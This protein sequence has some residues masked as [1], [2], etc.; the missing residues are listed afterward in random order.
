MFRCGSLAMA[1]MSDCIGSD[2]AFS[3]RFRAV[4]AASLLRPPGIAPLRLHDARTRTARF[5]CSTVPCH[6]RAGHMPVVR[7]SKSSTASTRFDKNASESFF[8]KTQ[9]FGVTKTKFY[10]IAIFSV[11]PNKILV[12]YN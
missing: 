10:V 8:Q 2:R 5:R 9:I 3:C 1:P 4:S 11:H 7:L 12:S 6:G